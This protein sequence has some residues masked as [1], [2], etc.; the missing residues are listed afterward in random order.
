MKYKVCLVR[1][2]HDYQTREIEV[3]GETLA[4][5]EL[6]AFDR[7]NEDGFW[8]DARTEVG[9]SDSPIIDSIEEIPN[10]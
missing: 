6:A 4:A 9:H 3:E 1:E 5:A 2:I 7:T 8:D 10:A